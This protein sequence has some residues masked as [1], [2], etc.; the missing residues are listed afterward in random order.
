VDFIVALFWG[1]YKKKSYER[2]RIAYNNVFRMFMK[3]GNR[4]SISKAMTGCDIPNFSA[5]Q[6]NY[7]GSFMQRLEKCDNLCVKI[8]CNWMGFYS[9]SIYKS[10]LSKLYC[11][12]N[13]SPF[14]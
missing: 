14:L 2:F 8:L 5:I 9:S 12:K 13:V 1:T 11:L 7:I 10:W 4:Q 6:K 3:I